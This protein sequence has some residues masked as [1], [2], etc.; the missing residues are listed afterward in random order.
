MEKWGINVVTMILENIA[1]EVK[2][3]YKK[4]FMDQSKTHKSNSIK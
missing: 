3:G 1:L 2:Y 4:R